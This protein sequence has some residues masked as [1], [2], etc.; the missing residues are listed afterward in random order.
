MNSNVNRHFTRVTKSIFIKNIPLSDLFII[1]FVLMD[2]W[3]QG[4][5]ILFLRVDFIFI[6]EKIK[7]N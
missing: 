2:D 3:Y 6:S 1:V 7:C 4:S 5:R